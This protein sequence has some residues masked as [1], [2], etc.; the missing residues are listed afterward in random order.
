MDETWSWLKSQIGLDGLTTLS[1]EPGLGVVPLIPI[2]V[3]GGSLA[4]MGK[5]IFDSKKFVGKIEEVKRLERK[6]YSSE[7]AVNMVEKLLGEKS[8]INLGKIMPIILIVGIGALIIK[9]KK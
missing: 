9:G 7:Q 6:G 5:W 2:A 4:L 8:L 1:N 3:I